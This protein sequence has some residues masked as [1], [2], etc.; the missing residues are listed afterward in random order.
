M[1]EEP[2]KLRLSKMDGMR[3]GSLGSFSKVVCAVWGS[4]R[5]LGTG[6][7]RQN[8]QHKGSQKDFHQSL[9]FRPANGFVALP[10]SHRSSL[11]GFEQESEKGQAAGE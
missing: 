2:R 7:W 8:G 9:V 6:M 10:V 3:E 11:K 5:W 4:E 1:L